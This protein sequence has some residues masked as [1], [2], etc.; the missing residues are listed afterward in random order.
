MLKVL[1]AAIL[2]IPGNLAAQPPQ[3]LGQPVILVRSYDR[4][5][6]AEEFAVTRSH[7][8]DILR[9]TGIGVSW[10][11]CG[12][13]SLPPDTLPAA[14]QQPLRANEF[15]VR[16][17]SAVDENAAIHRESLGYSL[18]DASTRGG[19]VAK[20]YADRIAALAGQADVNRLDLLARAIAHEIGHLLTGSNTHSRQG[21]MRA[22]WTTTELRRNLRRDWRFSWV[23]A[24]TMRQ[25][26]VTAALVAGDAVVA[27][28]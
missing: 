13:D 11:E 25:T 18:I 26:L 22:L 24:E 17:V 1:T 7:V 6:M 14:C 12:A 8:E 21:L 27:R 16:V 9:Q 2:L 19:S 20:V 10:L 4:L 3:P 5:A 28:H 23:Q 15:I